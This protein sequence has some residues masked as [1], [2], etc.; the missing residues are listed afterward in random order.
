LAYWGYHSSLDCAGANLEQMTDRDNVINFSKT[1]VE[2]IDM[3]PIGEPFVEFTA[4]DDPEKAGFSL[5]QLIVTS[6]ITA[7]FVD[8]NQTIY[9]DVFSCKKFDIE[10]V[11]ATIVEFFGVTKMK[12]QSIVRDALN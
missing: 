4:P 1:L 5:V 10:T 3:S 8:S 9:F 6:N 11:K 12:V 7:H 2:R